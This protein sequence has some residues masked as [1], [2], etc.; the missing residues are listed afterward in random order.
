MLIE[1]NHFYNYNY[2]EPQQQNYRSSAY[3]PRSLHQLQNQGSDTAYTEKRESKDPSLKRILIVDD[4]PDVTLTFKVGLEEHYYYHDD[5]RKFEVYTYNNPVTALSEFKP[6][7]YDLLLTDIN[8][9][10]MNGFEF[11]EKVLELDINIRICFISSADVN[12]EALREVY[13]KSRS[14]GC[15]IKKPASIEYLAKRLS[16]ELD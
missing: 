4:D 16:A 11:C 2:E 1:E 6:N 13:P 14:I 10:H 3:S 12:V 9:P 7:F 8:I 15:F 5:K